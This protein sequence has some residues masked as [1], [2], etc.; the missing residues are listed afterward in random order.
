MPDTGE[1]RILDQHE[2]DQQAGAGQQGRQRRRIFRI[3]EQRDRIDEIARSFG[4]PHT[5]LAGQCGEEDD[6]DR[7]APGLLPAFRKPV[8]PHQ[9]PETTHGRDRRQGRRLGRTVVPSVQQA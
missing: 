2:H 7:Q 1:A 6:H 5:G 4:Q 3:V 9:A 8:G